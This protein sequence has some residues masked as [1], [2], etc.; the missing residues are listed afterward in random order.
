M[1]CVVA[2]GPLRVAWLPVSRPLWVHR[3]RIRAARVVAVCLLLTASTVDPPGVQYRY[4]G[5]T[6][7]PVAGG[8]QKWVV[9]WSVMDRHVGAEVWTL[10]EAQILSAMVWSIGRRDR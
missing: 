5:T 3:M 8:G 2:L 7:Y 1:R 10:A 6:R 9:E 4:E